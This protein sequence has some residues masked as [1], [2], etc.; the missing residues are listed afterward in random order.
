MTS[1]CQADDL[2]TVNVM[3]WRVVSLVSG[4][5]TSQRIWGRFLLRSVQSI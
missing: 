2:E 4:R 1:S 5:Q 3:T